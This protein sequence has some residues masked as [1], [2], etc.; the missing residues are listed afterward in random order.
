MTTVLLFLFRV[1]LCR[2]LGLMCPRNIADF[3]YSKLK[4]CRFKDTV[5]GI[6]EKAISVVYVSP[7]SAE[8]LVRR[9]GIGNQRST[10]YCLTNSSAKSY[11][12]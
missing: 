2:C 12:N 6:I 7:S 1:F 8:T 3:G 5:Y 11:Q 4:H 9:G 10:A